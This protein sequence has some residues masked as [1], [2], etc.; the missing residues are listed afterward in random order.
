M[1]RSSCFAGFN[2]T[3]GLNTL[4][5][6]LTSPGIIST[7]CGLGDYRPPEAQISDMP[8]G[9]GSDS[10]PIPAAGLSAAMRNYCDNYYCLIQFNCLLGTKCSYS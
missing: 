8:R 9:I 5:I 6:T 7:I 1:Q 2:S 10:H 3:R 4:I